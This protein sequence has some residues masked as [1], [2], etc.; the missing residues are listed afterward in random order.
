MKLDEIAKRIDKYMK[1]FEAD[2]FVNREPISRLN[3]Y[4]QACA[5]RAGRYV[6]VRYLA[7]DRNYHLSRSEAEEYLAWLDAG[8]VGKHYQMLAEEREVHAHVVA[9]G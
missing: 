5:I 4:F 3:S 1:R 9:Q 8:H 7:Y 6:R 2:P